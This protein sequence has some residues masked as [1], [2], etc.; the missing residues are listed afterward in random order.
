MRDQFDTCPAFD[1]AD[2]CFEC[3]GKGYCQ[4]L[5]TE[6]IIVPQLTRELMYA[7]RNTIHEIAKEENIT[8]VDI[9]FWLMRKDWD[10]LGRYVHPVTGRFIELNEQYLFFDRVYD[11]VTDGT[12]DD[13]ETD[14]EFNIQLTPNR[15]SWYRKFLKPCNGLPYVPKKYLYRHVTILSIVR[16][17]F[18]DRCEHWPIAS[19][20]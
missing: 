3:E 17:A 18:P 13:S 7:A 20:K 2:L 8:C 11:G 16:A 5:T 1:H 9:P 19:S 14:S 12:E 6:I 4:E 15:H 10:Y